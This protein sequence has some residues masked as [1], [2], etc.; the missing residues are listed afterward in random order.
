MADAVEIAFHRAARALVAERT[1]LLVAVS[2]G[3]DSVA[4]LHLLHR[5]AARR[6]ST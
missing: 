1:A 3:G 2:G 5:F 4:L 6:R